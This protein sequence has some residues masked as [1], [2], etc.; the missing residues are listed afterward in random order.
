[1]A[2]KNYLQMEKTGVYLIASI[3]KI[4]AKDEK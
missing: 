4:D 1:L 3:L 2:V